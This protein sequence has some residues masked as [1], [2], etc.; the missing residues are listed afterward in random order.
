[1]RSCYKNV[2]YLLIIILLQACSGVGVAPVANRGEVKETAPTT[3]QRGTSR[4]SKPA[5]KAKPTI[6]NKSG[7]HIVGK[8]DTLYSIAWRYNMIINR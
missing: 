1:M 6:Q 5:P 4:Q 8:G 7:Y 3:T 2:I